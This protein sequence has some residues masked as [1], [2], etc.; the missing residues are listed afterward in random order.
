MEGASAPSS[1]LKTGPAMGH[2]YTA[3]QLR[4]LGYYKRVDGMWMTAGGMILTN[5]D[6]IPEPLVSGVE[7]TLSERQKTHG[8]FESN[9][10]CAQEIKMVLRGYGFDS[11][12]SIQREALD[13]IAL[14]ISRILTGDCDHI[15]NWHDIAG[16]ATL[17]EKWL[18][19]K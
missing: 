13:Q 14:K 1:F 2:K 12:T 8:D 10:R 4:E 7:N 6:E 11:L 9:A 3:T 18:S 16:Y 17:V 5:I 19:P 15:D